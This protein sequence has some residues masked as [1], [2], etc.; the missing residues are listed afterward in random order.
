MT[1]A[2]IGDQ[3]EEG[4]YQFHSRFNRA[5]N[6]TQGDGLVAVVDEEVGDGPLNIVLRDFD[7]GQTQNPLE[8]SAD[9]VVFEGREFPFTPRHRYCSTLDGK[10]GPHFRDNLALF[11]ELL[12]TTSHRK[13]LAFLLDARRTENFRAG[14]ERTF[15]AQVKQSVSKVFHGDRLDGV[16]TL[17]GCGIGLTPSGDDFIAGLLIALHL[18][19]ETVD[20][21]FEAARSD[22]IFSNSFLNLARQGRLFG[23]MKNL[24]LALMHGGDAAVR[25][26]TRRLLAIGESSGADLGTGF[27]IT[28][29]AS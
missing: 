3:V 1:L 17:S 28:I 10:L 21:I 4:T 13:S 22:N 8:V 25:E 7:A 12:A 24:I 23:R 5:V 27:Y 6:F 20:D 2:S 19:G 15:A 11:G 9:K 16:R 14:F 18:R 29:R 26:A